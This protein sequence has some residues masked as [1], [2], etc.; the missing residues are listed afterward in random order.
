[1]FIIAIITYYAGVLVWK[2][3]DQRMDEIVDSLPTPEWVAYLS[4]LTALA[5]TVMLVQLLALVSGVIAQACYGY[6][7][8]QLGLYFNQ[9]FLRDGSFFLFFG[10]VGIFHSRPFTQ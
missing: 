9:L 3:R 1:M 7:R 6:H 10:G 4:R 2:D 5:V 8:Y